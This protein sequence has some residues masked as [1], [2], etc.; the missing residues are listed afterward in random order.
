MTRE[1]GTLMAKTSLVVE[2]HEHLWSLLVEAAQYEHM[3]TC[4]C[5]YACFSLKTGPDEGL[6]A[7]QADAVARW[8]RTLT[9]IAVEEMLHLALVMN[10]M[11][12]VGGAPSQSRP[13]FPRHSEFR[14]RG[15]VR[16]AAVRRRFPHAFPVPRPEGME[17]VD[18]SEFVPAAPPVLAGMLR[19]HSPRPLGP[20]GPATPHTGARRHQHFRSSDD[21][22]GDICR[23]RAINRSSPRIAHGTQPTVSVTSRSARKSR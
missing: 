1:P 14:P 22:R 10:V 4:Q 12:A 17:R 23:G 8:Q 19:Q 3:I 6:A 18:A 9:G 16:S 5:L 21:I 11:T 15:G 20:P 7:D 2:H 13:D